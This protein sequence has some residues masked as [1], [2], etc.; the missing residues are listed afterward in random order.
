[1]DVSYKNRKEYYYT[2]LKKK[3]KTRVYKIHITPYTL[4]MALVNYDTCNVRNLTSICI[5]IQVNRECVVNNYKARIP[6]MKILDSIYIS[7]NTH[8]SRIYCLP[9]Y[10]Y[11]YGIYTVK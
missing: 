11:Q 8:A 4:K 5:V 3:K 2:K 6:H 10:I 7:A 9:F 1:M